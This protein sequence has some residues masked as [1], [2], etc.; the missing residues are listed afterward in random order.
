MTDGDA[1][2]RKSSQNLSNVQRYFEAHDMGRGRGVSL[3]ESDSLRGSKTV[4]PFDPIDELV[5]DYRFLDSEYV[6]I[7]HIGDD[8]DLRD[9]DLYNE[10]MHSE[11]TSEGNFHALKIEGEGYE[12]IVKEKDILD[13]VTQILD[14]KE[15]PSK[16]SFNPFSNDLMVAEVRGLENIE[17][18][19][20]GIAKDEVFERVVRDLN[21]YTDIDDYLHQQEIYVEEVNDHLREPVQGDRSLGAGSELSEEVSSDLNSEKA[22]KPEYN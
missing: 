15:I 3:F 12:I 5:D 10:K 22:A 14:Q 1:E 7:D 19:F 4:D 2:D 9:V 18:N 13:P 17:R 6:S 16:E 8:T 20:K 11:F 21:E